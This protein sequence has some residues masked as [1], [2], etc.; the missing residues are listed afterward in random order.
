MPVPL[1]PTSSIQEPQYHLNENDLE[2]FLGKKKKDPQVF[3][4]N[5]DAELLINIWEKSSKT[6]DGKH[7]TASAT[8]D[9]LSKLEYGGFI[10]LDNDKKAFSLTGLGKNVLKIRVLGEGNNFLKSRKKKNYKEIMASN[11]DNS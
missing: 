1:V 4:K 3:A 9:E 2:R 5:Q 11:G 10:K 8:I 6:K 7:I